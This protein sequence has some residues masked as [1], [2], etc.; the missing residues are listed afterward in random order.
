[1]NIEN[2]FHSGV[3]NGYLKNHKFSF[4]VFSELIKIDPENDLYR[5][6]YSQMKTNLLSQK[7]R[8]VGYIGLAMVFGDIIS[9]LAF[10]YDFD[11]RIV[12]IGFILILLS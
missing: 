10:N 7:L 12:L 8:I 4:E 1:M 6:W 11:K 9:G 5:N 2:K 3:L